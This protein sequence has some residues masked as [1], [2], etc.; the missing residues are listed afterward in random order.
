MST[1]PSPPETPVFSALTTYHDLLHLPFQV[2]GE[3]Y[4]SDRKRVTEFRLRG[5]RL[6]SV[7]S[8]ATRGHSD[9]QPLV[10]CCV[11][12]GRAIPLFR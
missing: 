4:T 8:C 1:G 12:D 2:C 11:E 6:Q 7:T 5:L 9:Y 3:C 10:K